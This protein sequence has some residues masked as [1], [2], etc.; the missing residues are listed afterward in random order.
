MIDR[1][2]T[3]ACGSVIALAPEVQLDMCHVSGIAAIGSIPERRSLVRTSRYQLASHRWNGRF[4]DQGS[5]WRD[6]RHGRIAGVRLAGLR[7]ESIRW[8]S[9]IC[10]ADVDFSIFRAVSARLCSAPV[11]CVAVPSF[12]IDGNALPGLL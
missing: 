10:L 11:S 2:I 8:W 5:R 9:G 6:G 7:P 12:L 3:S 1:R 4:S